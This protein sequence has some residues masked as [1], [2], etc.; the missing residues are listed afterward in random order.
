MTEDCKEASLPISREEIETPRTPSALRQ[1]VDQ[2]RERVKLNPD[3]RKAG[4]LRRGYYKEFLDEVVPLSRFAVQAYPETHTIQPI[5]GN[6]G[7][8][9]IV[10]GADGRIVDK[11]EIANPIDGMAAAS[12]AREVAARGIGGV[13]VGNPG[14]EIEELI[15]II[16]RTASKKALI[17]YLDTT[18]VFNVS[19]LP[20]FKEFEARH[21]DLIERIRG[22]LTAAGFKARRVYILHPPEHLERIDGNAQGD[23][24]P[25]T[26]PNRASG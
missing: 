24:L 11:V 4:L 12:T 15:P 7:Y 20:A 19:A 9:A 22:A 10:R 23:V 25:L 8:D 1:F 13:R 14:D 18:V 16:E 21:E 3:E 5:L 17:D 6:Q 2:V 26:S